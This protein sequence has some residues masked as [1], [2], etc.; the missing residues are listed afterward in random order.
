MTDTHNQN[1]GATAHLVAHLAESTQQCR[2]TTRASAHLVA[3][4]AHELA[5]AA[6]RHRLALLPAARDRLDADLEQPRHDGAQRLGRV[7]DDALP[8]VHRRLA[9]RVRRVV[10]A[11]VVL[12]V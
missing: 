10:P 8:D 5:E 12:G 6:A 7:H 3:H 11:C 2:H 1:S 9:H 4:L